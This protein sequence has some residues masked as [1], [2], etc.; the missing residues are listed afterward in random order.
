[1][2]FSLIT[3]KE[4][5]N[6]PN[7]KTE[8]GL[9]RLFSKLDR[10]NNSLDYDYFYYKGFL[11]ICESLGWDYGSVYTSIDAGLKIET[12]IKFNNKNNRLFDC[13]ETG[14]IMSLRNDITYLTLNPNYVIN[15]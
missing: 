12:T 9:K 15:L 4:L 1:M 14:D 11:Y 2:N 7:I 6:I 5:G 3:K 10:H 13:F 8:L